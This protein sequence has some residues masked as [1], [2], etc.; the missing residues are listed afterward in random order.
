MLVSDRSDYSPDAVAHSEVTQGQMQKAQALLACPLLLRV[1]P[2][3]KETLKQE[4]VSACAIWRW[5][6]CLDPLI[7]DLNSCSDVPFNFFFLIFIFL[8]FSLGTGSNSELLLR[9]SQNWE[10]RGILSIYSQMLPLRETFS[11]SCGLM[12]HYFNNHSNLSVSL[13]SL[14]SHGNK[15]TFQKIYF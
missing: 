15:R 6:L 11:L 4:Y 3:R 1:L 5:R 13:Q 14:K 12:F 8:P 10:V 7:A 9:V 2:L